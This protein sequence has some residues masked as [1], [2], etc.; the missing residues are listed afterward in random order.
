MIYSGD[1]EFMIV[2]PKETGF[3]DVI[4][5]TIYSSFFNEGKEMLFLKEVVDSKQC[6]VEIDYYIP[7]I[8]SLK[9][10]TL[11]EPK[12]CWRTGNFK[13]SLLEISIDQ[14]TGI[15]REITLTLVNMAHF[16]DT[17]LDC[18]HIVEKG[19]PVFRLEG[20][21]K[22]NLCDQEVDFE[23]YFNMEFVKVDF[24]NRSQPVKYIELERVLFGFDKKERLIS[25]I[26]KDL[27]TDE[28][29]E[30]LDSMNPLLT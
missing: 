9:T 4:R 30:L 13:N 10:E 27:T 7:F 23:V 22:N 6:E 20:D 2:P 24:G 19:T 17:V 1:W 5:P 25:V 3:N 16:V 28:Y 26:I 14:K 29:R 8:I 12:V 21:L 18:V 15:L 11:Y